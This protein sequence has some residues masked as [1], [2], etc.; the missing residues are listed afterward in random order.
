V[1]HAAVT[2]D[3]GRK[4]YCRKCARLATI[5]DSTLDPRYPLVQ[6]S[7]R[8]QAGKHHGHGL[9][10]GTY[11]QDEALGLLHARQER[12]RARNHAAMR[13]A[14]RPVRECLDCQ[15]EAGHSRHR[16]LRISEPGCPE[17]QA[18]AR[19]AGQAVRV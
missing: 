16:A 3:R 19:A 15:R 5:W 9:L 18:I 1:G 11:D 2:V 12:T 8:D 6:C 13:H 10:I 4:V 14:D 17:C 7:W